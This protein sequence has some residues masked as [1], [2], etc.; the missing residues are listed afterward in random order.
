MNI[1]TYVL[2]G[3]N[4]NPF[5]LLSLAGAAGIYVWQI[6]GRGKPAYFVAA[7]LL[8]V[9]ALLSPLNL[10]ATGVLFSA[11]MAQHIVLL[12]LV[13][14]LVLLSLPSDWGSRRGA[15]ALQTPMGGRPLR[16][17]ERRPT[18]GVAAAGWLLGVGSMWFWHVPQFCDA[19]ATYA[20]VH[21]AQAL[22][23][24]GMGTAFWWPILSPRPT[25][26]LMPGHGIIYLFTACLACTALGILL[27]L[28]TVAVCPIFAAPST[29]PAMWIQ[30]RHELTAHRDQQIGGLLMWLPMCLVYVAAIVLELARW[31]GEP[32]ST[33][34]AT[35]EPSA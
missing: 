15:S 14:G 31:H 10:L 34:V 22:S 4:W 12:L 30:L 29:A 24:L 23:L 35:G 8:V 6:G 17:Q 32:A 1:L 20:P 27:T 18:N 21:A 3:W 25:D 13:P 11:H 5:V 26:R 19:A 28:T 2:H 16:R 7:L 9:I 33:V